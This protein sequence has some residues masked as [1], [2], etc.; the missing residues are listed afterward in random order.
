M[1]ISDSLK[2]INGLPAA[3]APN[4]SNAS[5]TSNASNVSNA[6]TTSNARSLDNAATAP[7][8]S[9]SVRLSQQGQ[10]LAANT[11]SNNV[12]FNAQ[13]V[14]RIKLAITDGQ[15]QV[16]S[17]KVADGLLEAARQLL[18]TRTK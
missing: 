8:A 18:P 3:P 14:E 16:N 12:V 13:K 6:S 17:E 11:A 9:D 10:A 7:A 4:A 2:G 5:N 15:F 1:K